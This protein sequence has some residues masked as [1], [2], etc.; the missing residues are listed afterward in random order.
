MALR[1]DQ[2]QALKDSLCLDNVEPATRS[3]L[4]N[5]V[6]NLI[7]L[8][9]ATALPEL[10]DLG[11]INSGAGINPGDEADMLGGTPPLGEGEEM[12]FDPL[13]GF[14]DAPPGGGDNQGGGGGITCNDEGSKH[15][16]F[17]ATTMEE[18][19]AAKNGIPGQGPVEEQQISEQ[20]GDAQIE[21]C[22][23]ECEKQYQEDVE[24]LDNNI[25]IYE[26]RLREGGISD[27][28][29]DV[30]NEE[31]RTLR[32]QRRELSKPYDECLKN[33][34]P[35]N[36]TKPEDVIHGSGYVFTA[37]NISCEKIEKD[38]QVIVSGRVNE[39]VCRDAFGT[40][41]SSSPIPGTENV[42]ITV[43]SCGCD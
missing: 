36:D 20:G 1:K 14:E 27:Q 26:D 10:G 17:L 34:E 25:R 5:L 24:H 37:Q 31:I 30:Y 6:D 11:G 22:R 7:P 41:V 8:F 12:P 4:N 42:F 39:Y 29:I 21:A 40:A 16:T 19:P 13:G 9:E 38:T 23:R 3:A 35:D 43:E 28:I 2:I 18:I 15:V 33:C 32:K